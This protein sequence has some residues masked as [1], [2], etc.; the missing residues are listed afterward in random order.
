MHTHSFY[1]FKVYFIMT[2]KKQRKCAICACDILPWDHHQACIEYRNNKK[3]KDKCVTGKE[4]DCSN[5]V[6]SLKIP[7]KKKSSKSKSS[8]KFDD[9]LLDELNLPN[10]HNPLLPLLTTSSGFD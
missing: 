1:H 7:H 3:G 5:C 4:S 8:D 2:D 9:S 10:H 6:G